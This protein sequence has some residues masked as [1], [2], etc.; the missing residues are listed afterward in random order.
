MSQVILLPA[1]ALTSGNLQ[2]ITTEK[3]GIPHLWG[4]KEANFKRDTNFKAKNETF[5]LQ[6]LGFDHLVGHRK[7]AQT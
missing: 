3:L 1:D 5:W 7:L 2:T 6:E 4:K